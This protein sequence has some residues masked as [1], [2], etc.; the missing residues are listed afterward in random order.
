MTKVF[1]CSPRQ[2]NL[3]KMI[4]QINDCLFIYM[5]FKAMN[6][7]LQRHPHFVR[8]K[9]WFVC[10][11]GVLHSLNSINTGTITPGEIHM[12]G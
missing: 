6:H 7:A 11:C 10:A 1:S 2:N 5:K 8:R 9:E 12:L 3:T 4:A